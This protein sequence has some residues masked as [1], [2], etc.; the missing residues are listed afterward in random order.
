MSILLR[1]R[2]LTA[3]IGEHF[4]SISTDLREILVSHWG[5]EKP[6]LRRG[7]HWVNPSSLI[8]GVVSIANGQAAL[9]R[10]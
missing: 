10:R 4:A 8:G 1:V 5:E 3:V 9:G 7:E 6:H 2:Y